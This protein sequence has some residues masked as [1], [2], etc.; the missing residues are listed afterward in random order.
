[1]SKIKSGNTKPEI[2]LRKRLWAEGVRYRLNYKKLPGKPDI[3]IVRHKIVVFVDGTFWHGYNWGY[4]KKKI[5]V[6]RSYWLPKIEKT[7]KRDIR[8]NF[9]IKKQGWKV[10]RFWD[11]EINKNMEKCVRKI[12]KII[13]NEKK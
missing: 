9:L 5:K 6:N 10:I 7:I 4:K 13:S 8:Y 1:M 12:K 2:V 11:F 3:A